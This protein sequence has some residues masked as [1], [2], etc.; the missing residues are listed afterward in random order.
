MTSLFHRGVALAAPALLA[1]GA[2]GL[3]APAPAGDVVALRAGSAH[4]VE[5]GEVLEGGVTLIVREGRIAAVGTDVAVP[6]GA[7]VVDYGP[8][9]TLMPGI[10]AAT[11]YH[12]SGGLPERTASPGTRAIDAFDPYDRGWADELAEG[13]TTAYLLPARDRLIAGQGAVVKLAGDDPAARV[14]EESACLHGSIARDAR[15][16]PGFW[17]PPVP[18]TVDVGM[19]YAE[20]QLPKTTMGAIVALRELLAAAAAGDTGTEYGPN[21]PL[22]LRALL[23]AKTPWRMRAETVP[24]IRALLAFARE[25]GVPLVLEGVQ[26]GADVAQEI[27]NAGVGAIVEVDFHPDRSPLRDLGK[28]PDAVWPR[29]DAAAAL[30]AAGVPI[31]IAGPPDAYW[32]SPRFHAALASRGG[33]DPAEA[34]RAITLGPAELLGVADRV[35]SLTVGKDADVVVVHGSPLSATTGV[36]ATWVAGELAWQ[37]PSDDAVTVIEVDELHVG[38]GTVLRPGQALIR[39]GRILE[40]G[41]RVSRPGGARVVRGVAAMPGMIDAYGHLGL[42]GS[43]K[44]PSADFQLTRIVEPGDETDRRVARAGVTTVF[45]GPRGSNKSGVPVMAYRP[46]AGDPDDLVVR[47]RVAVG[48]E[49]ENRNRLES[50]KDVREVIA[51]AKEYDASWREYEEAM[52]SWKPPV[53]PLEPPKLDDDADEDE[54]SA[55]DEEAEEEDEEDDKDSRKK[56]RKKKGDDEEPVEVPG[57]WLGQ[58][59]VPP[60]EDASRL[61]LRLEADSA[62]GAANAVIGYLRCDPLSDVLVDLRGSIDGKALAL[63]GLGSKGRVRVAGEISGDDFAGTVALGDTELEVELKR[64]TRELKYARRPERKRAEEGEGDEAEKKKFKDAPKK[65]KTDDKLELWRAAMRGELAI[66]VTVNRRDEIL[67]CVEAFEEVGVRPVLVGAS[68]AW[69]IADELRGR[70]SGVL[71]SPVVRRA[72]PRGGLNSRTNRYAELDSAGI[73][74]AFH[75][76]AEEG[77]AQLPLLASWAVAQGMSPTGALRALTS[78]PAEMMRVDDEIGRLAEGLAADVLVLDGPPLEPATRVLRAWVGGEEVR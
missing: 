72:E 10:V 73:P 25:S 76:A 54:K 40:V 29:Y 78:G 52:A 42:E 38:D 11:T 66:L 24:E 1:A 6:A 57:I 59:T 14:L 37:A 34:L 17:E 75:S 27:A 9:A 49:W 5:G 39:D 19:G 41:A 20:P 31:A 7:R 67:A 77:A 56:K 70:V 55:D 23:D 60:M 16:T 36:A 12:G 28:G 71:L 18:A 4:L 2:L 43:K 62:S 63:A 45:L 13:V 51:K 44:A 48:Y 46:A 8:D 65:P 50:G 21:A 69:R 53:E 26:A 32:A 58:V 22:E 61:R 33:L 68:D 15:S 64:E 74:V 35:G 3:T 47:P 30:R